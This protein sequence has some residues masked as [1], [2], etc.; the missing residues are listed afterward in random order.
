MLFR[1]YEEEGCKVSKVTF[2]FYSKNFTEDVINNEGVIDN[3]SVINT[4]DIID[5][6]GIID[7]KSVI[8]HID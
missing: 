2:T 1:S 6:E 3:K 4:E 8:Y 7:N 5:N